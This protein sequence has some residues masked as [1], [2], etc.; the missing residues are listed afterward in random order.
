M[1]SRQKP[2]EIF[3]GINVWGLSEINLHI[4]QIILLHYFPDNSSSI[5]SV[6]QIMSSNFQ[7][8]RNIPGHGGG[9]HYPLQ[10]YLDL[11]ILCGK[12]LLMACPE[13]VGC[14]IRNYH[15]VVLSGTLEKEVSLDLTPPH[16]LPSSTDP[17]TNPYFCFKLCSRKF[18]LFFSVIQIISSNY[19][20]NRHFPD[21]IG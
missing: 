7:L 12:I 17:P 11:S 6:F 18:L 9:G 15:T 13:N 8:P 3:Y 20:D 2:V 1:I 16:T 14:L 10:S 21:L 4:F 5:F 19:L